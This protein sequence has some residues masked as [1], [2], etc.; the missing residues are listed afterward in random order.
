MKSTLEPLEGNKIKLS[1]EVEEVEF[2]KDIDAAFR[3]LALE[4]RLPGFRPGKVPVA[5]IKQRYGAAV[6][7]H[8]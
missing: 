8:T 5:V 1:V 6:R 2:A 3:K 7:D 4:V